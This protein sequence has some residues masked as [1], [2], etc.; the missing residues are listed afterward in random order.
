MTKTKNAFN[1][2]DNNELHSEKVREF[3]GEI[4]PKLTIWGFVIICIS[5]L[6][7]IGIM[8]YVDYPYGSGET[9]FQY[10]F[11]LLYGSMI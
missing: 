1:Q 4:P 8:S 11:S 10:V 9:I 3:L 6:I 2:N 7:I 5:F